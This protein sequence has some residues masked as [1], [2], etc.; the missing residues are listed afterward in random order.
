M[1]FYG[2]YKHEIGAAGYI[3]WNGQ[4]K[5]TNGHGICYQNVPRKMT[6]NVVEMWAARDCL[7]FVEAQ[8]YL[9]NHKTI[10]MRGDSYFIANFMLKNTNLDQTLVQLYKQCK[11]NVQ[12]GVSSS[13]SRCSGNI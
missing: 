3:G 4:G 11:H 12:D 1:H 8:G 2:V 10:V 13:R 9:K 6:H 7:E 5:C